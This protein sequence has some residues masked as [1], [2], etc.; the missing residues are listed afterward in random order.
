MS[1][2]WCAAILILIFWGLII[3]FGPSVHIRDYWTTPMRA[4]IYAR[5]NCFD[6]LECI[7]GFA[8]LTVHN[9]SVKFFPS[10]FELIHASILGYWSMSASRF[11]GVACWLLIF[12]L[13]VAAHKSF[14]PTPNIISKALYLYW[15]F[16]CTMYIGFLRFSA[17]FS[18][19]RSLPALCVASSA[20]LL[21]VPL[22]KQITKI[23][24]PLLGILSV[25]SLFSFA[26][27]A[28]LFLAVMATLAL[29]KSKQILWFSILASICFYFYSLI[30]NFGHSSG[31]SSKASPTLSKGFSF[32][33]DFAVWPIS[34]ILENISLIAL[35]G[36]LALIIIL[37]LYLQKINPRISLSSEL[38]VGNFRSALGFYSFIILF[39]SSVP[40]LVTLQR[41]YSSMQERYFIESSLFNA[42][43]VG[44]LLVMM[45]KLQMHKAK[46]IILLISGSLLAINL[47]M[48]SDL[49]KS[50]S[51]NYLYSN[52]NTVECLQRAPIITTKV[53][54]NCG[55]DKEFGL[56]R[57]HKKRGDR[58][59]MDEYSSGLNA[60]LKRTK[61]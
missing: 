4:L 61:Q 25:I 6:L 1:L 10:A 60:V 51:D 23:R 13:L 52:I 26:N 53:V 27:G 29:K 44:V 55:V 41:G 36:G 43:I 3:V 42:A 39:Y 2:F 28:L 16:I 37:G 22:P 14:F 8:Q 50:F 38:E 57:Y 18:I 9:D 49:D 11:I 31:W 7:N 15:L 59:W 46:F 32:L 48:L 56:W 58:V 30:V 24:I 54:E 21:W 45:L 17:P 35:L 47:F 34:S 40:V 12:V 5:T 20:Y 33:L 19:H